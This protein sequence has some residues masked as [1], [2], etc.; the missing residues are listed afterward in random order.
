MFSPTPTQKDIKWDCVRI[1]KNL[2]TVQPQT[3]IPVSKDTP[4]TS[5]NVIISHKDGVALGWYD[6]KH[7]IKDGYSCETVK[8]WMPLPKAYEV[9]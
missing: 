6:G 5:A 8:A 1:V 4:K 3:W 2:P 7:W 9:K